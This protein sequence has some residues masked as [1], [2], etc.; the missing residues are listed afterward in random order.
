[1]K[2]RN[3]FGLANV[4]GFNVSHIRKAKNIS[5]KDFVLLLRKNGLN[6][7]N[8]SYSKLEGQ[9]RLATDKEIYA[10]AKALDVEMEDLFDC[11][12]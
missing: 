10:I 7:D 9:T 4:I 12:T 11:N 6:I 2:Y 1:M 3:N 8:L 5:Q